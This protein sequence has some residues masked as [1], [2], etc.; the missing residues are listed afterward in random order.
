MADG[1]GGVSGVEGDVVVVGNLTVPRVGGSA[2][3]IGNPG[4]GPSP[5][6]VLPVCAIPRALGV[7]HGLICG[8]FFGIFLCDIV[9]GFSV[10]QG[11]TA[12]QGAF[13]VVDFEFRS[14][15]GR[16]IGRYDLCLGQLEE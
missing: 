1:L 11:G 3:N 4:G 2:V 10:G 13:V 12:M 15:E 8:Y 16:E 6:D 9:E 7:S 14:P 5:V